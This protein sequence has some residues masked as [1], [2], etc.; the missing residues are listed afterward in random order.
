[1]ICANIVHVGIITM[2][3]VRDKDMKGRGLRRT[4]KEGLDIGRWVNGGLGGKG[5]STNGDNGLPG[6]S[7]RAQEIVESHKTKLCHVS[8]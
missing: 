3:K 1:M 7:I 6:M 5:V 8:Q 2:M 4:G